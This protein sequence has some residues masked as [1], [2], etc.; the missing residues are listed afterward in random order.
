M[1]VPGSPLE[2][3]SAGSNR[4]L[5]QGAILIRDADD[6][7]EALSN[8]LSRT[9]KSPPPTL[10]DDPEAQPV[11]PTGQIEAVKLLLGPHPL[12]IHEIARAANIGSARCASIL[13]ELEIAGEAVTFAGGFAALAL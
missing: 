3:R 7:I 5:R 6:V 2:P 9:M 4:L 12:P 1:A 13:V 11:I 8:P 10:Y